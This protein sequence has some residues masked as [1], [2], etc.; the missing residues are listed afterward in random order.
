MQF[1][2]SQIAILESA[3]ASNINI[4][5]IDPHNIWHEVYLIINSRVCNFITIITYFLI[6]FVSINS[7]FSFGTRTKTH[8]QDNCIKNVNLI[9]S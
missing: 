3:G 4:N 2:L 9:I 5:I 7:V 6:N 1:A 8:L